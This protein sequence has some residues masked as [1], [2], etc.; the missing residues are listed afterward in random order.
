MTEL[1]IDLPNELVD[2]IAERA[3]AIVLDRLSVH[4]QPEFLTVPR[5]AAYIDAKP[6]RIRDLLSQRRLT[7][8]KDGGRTLVSRVELDAHLAGEIVGPI[9]QLLPTTSQS[10]TGRRSAA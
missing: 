4:D 1:V 3:A 2:A 6:Q 10:R 5:A 7:T 8:Y 9:A